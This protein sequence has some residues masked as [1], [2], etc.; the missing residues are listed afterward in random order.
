MKDYIFITWIR[1]LLLKAGVYDMILLYIAREGTGIPEMLRVFVL[2]L[3]VSDKRREEEA[4][5]AY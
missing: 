4:V 1:A 2:A 3:S 5:A